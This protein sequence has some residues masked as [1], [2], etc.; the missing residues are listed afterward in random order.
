MTS[1]HAAPSFPIAI[2]CPVWSSDRWGD[3]VYPPRTPRKE[4]LGWYTRMFNTVEGNSTFYAL[5]SL[6]V[7]KRMTRLRPRLQDALRMRFAISSGP[8]RPCFPCHPLHQSS[9]R[10]STSRLFLLSSSLASATRQGPYHA[11]A[12]CGALAQALPPPA[13]S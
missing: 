12:T 4:W 11:T 10:F 9:L 6:D 13:R 2:G 8:K 7:A 1:N 3:V 5:P